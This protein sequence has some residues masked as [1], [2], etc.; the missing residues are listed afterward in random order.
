MSVLRYISHP[1]VDIDP[2]RPVAQWQL[3]DLGRHRAHALLDHSWI[4][5]IGLVISSAET[6]AL[7]T[8]HFIAARL[9]LDVE[10]RRSTGEIDRSATGFVEP[11]LHEWLADRFFAE[12]ALSTSGWERAVDAQR[13]IV[14]A[15]SDVLDAPLDAVDAVGDVAVIGHGAVGTLLMCH[16][17]S[18]AISRGHD[19]PGQGH[20]WSYDR[21]DR[22]LLHGWQPIDDTLSPPE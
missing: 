22:R 21:C 18:R 10:V 8:A 6:K 20:Y 12:P 14:D 2:H 3:S 1:D 17:D 15:V 16:L 11:D 13:R 9:D 5:S 4:D 7:E 19:Q